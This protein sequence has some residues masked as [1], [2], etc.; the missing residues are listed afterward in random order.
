M[1]TDLVP[2]KFVL[3]SA[4]AAKKALTSVE[5]VQP[6]ESDTDNGITTEMAKKMFHLHCINSGLIFLPQSPVFTCI[7]YSNN[8]G[9]SISNEIPVTLMKLNLK[10]HDGYLS[11]WQARQVAKCYVDNTINSILEQWRPVERPVDASD[12][13]E[14]CDNDGQIED[15]GILMAIQSHGLQ[16]G[17]NIDYR[18]GGISRDCNISSALFQSAC[19]E[20]S[21]LDNYENVYYE[22]RK[23]AEQEMLCDSDLEKGEAY[24]ITNQM[25]FLSAAVSVAIQNKGLPSYSCG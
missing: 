25:G 20:E 5:C 13:V 21:A 11:K 14:N 10:T 15:E 24:E 19:L 18:G 3:Q 12:F 2:Y 1:K 7:C 16:S 4:S 22:S 6:T 23:N 9:R 17:N 8:I